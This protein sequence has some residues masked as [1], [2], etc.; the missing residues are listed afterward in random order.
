MAYF[1]YIFGN[2]SKWRKSMGIRTDS[3][4]DRIV[5]DNTAEY[6]I[7]GAARNLRLI[8]RTELGKQLLALRNR[9]IAEGMKLRSCDEI[10]AEIEAG[11]VSRG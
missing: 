5:A 3:G 1:D 8:P 4:Y 7:E 11:R 9:A 10:L 2:R 6:S